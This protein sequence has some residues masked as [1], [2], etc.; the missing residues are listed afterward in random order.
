MHMQYEVKCLCVV[1][2]G[3]NAKYGKMLMQNTEK[4]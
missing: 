3:V 2:Y 1:L 4:R